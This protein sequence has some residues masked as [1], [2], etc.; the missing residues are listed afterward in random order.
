MKE[1]LSRMLGFNSN[2]D[3]RGEQVQEIDTTKIQANPFQPRKHF[4]SVQLDELAKSIREYGVIQ[5]IIVRQVNGGYE[6][7]AGERRLRATQSLGI[8]KIPA[9]VR[10][11][12]DKDIAELAL[13]ENLQREDLNYF[14]EAEGFKRLMQEFDL[15]QEDIA[16]R[17]GKSQSTIANKLRLLKLDPAVKENINAEII[18]ERHA[19]ALLKLPDAAAQITAL[20]EIYEHELNVRETDLL[21]EQ[22]LSSQEQQTGKKD[23]GK[24]IVRIFKDMRIYVNTIKQ[25]VSAIEGAGL[26][27]KMT[28]T[29]HEDF[30][31]VV[32]QIPKIKK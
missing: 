31:E 18:T 3:D 16:K 29:N 4:D 14:E 8:Q 26:N 19:R 32:I 15:T 11:L 1:S 22:L 13:I 5:P 25:A 6:L 23:S 30:I 7:V 9:I 12:S 24:K 10:Q 17:V 27:V 21:V 2:A 28:E 20:K